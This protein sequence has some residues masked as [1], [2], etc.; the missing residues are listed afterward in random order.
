MKIYYYKSSVGSF[1]IRGDGWL[2]IFVAD[3]F[4]QEVELDF[5]IFVFIYCNG[6]G[7][8]CIST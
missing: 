5:H 6:R 8:F 2:C 4:E 3:L 7:A 1:Y